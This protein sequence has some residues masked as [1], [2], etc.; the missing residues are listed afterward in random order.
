IKKGGGKKGKSKQE[1]KAAEK[2]QKTA[3]KTAEKTRAKAYTRDSLQA[4]SKLGELVD[5]RYRIVSQPPIVVPARELKAAY[6]MSA[7]EVDHA[8]R[9]QLRAYRATLP[10][11]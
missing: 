3:E 4:L 8:L 10:D 6:G 11:D 1:V 7:D 5:G 9:E 2:A